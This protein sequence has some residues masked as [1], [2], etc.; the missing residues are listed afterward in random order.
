M[1]DI[2]ARRHFPVLAAFASANVLLAFD[3]DGT[4]TPIVSRPD[5]ARVR[6]RTRRLLTEIARRYPC[7]VISGRRLDDVTPRLKNIPVWHVFGNFGHEP[8]DGNAAPPAQVQ[9]WVRTLTE[10]LGTH[11]QVVIEAK[12]YSVTVHYRHVRNKRRLLEALHRA[13]ASLTDARV[14]Q[15]PQ[16]VTLLPRGGPDKGVALQQAR[17][18]FACDAAI[19]IGDDE[20]DE[21]AFTSDGPDRLLSVRIGR[22]RGSA[23]R[24]SLKRQ[25]HIDDLL[26]TLLALRD[27]RQQDNTDSRQREAATGGERRV[28]RTRRRFLPRA[29]PN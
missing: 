27:P 11:R 23:A 8:A 21:D 28:A 18:L 22:A 24:Y 16:A 15:S 17:R 7:A 2:L 6:P 26:A 3:Y 19:Y 13:V 12:Q 29:R 25:S 1:A 5:R 20:T 10:Q 4:L 9:E 14:L